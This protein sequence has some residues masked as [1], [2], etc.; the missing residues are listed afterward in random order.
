MRFRI[1][2]VLLVL[3]SIPSFAQ[4][5]QRLREDVIKIKNAPEDTSLAILLNDIGWDT[6]YENLEAGLIY[7]RR[8]LDLSKKLNFNYGIMVSANSLGTIYNDQGAYDSALTMH[9]LSLTTAQKENNLYSQ[10]TT[11]M[12]LSIVY[13]SMG[14]GAKALECLLKSKDI[15]TT[16][17]SNRG[18][19][20]VNNNLG[21]S[22][23]DFDSLG[24]AMVAFQL[25]DS[26]SDLLQ[27]PDYKAHA[28]SGLSD[29]YRRMEDSTNSLKY[30]R[31]T[32]AILD[33]LHDV[34]DVGQALYD[35][36]YNYYHFKEYDKAETTYMQALAIFRKVGMVDQ[37]KTLWGDLSDLYE[38]KGEPEKALVAMKRFHELKDSIVNEKVLSHQ[39][40]LEALYQNEKNQNKI[41][42]LTLDQKFQNTLVTAL[43][44]GV[45]L[46]IV[47]LFVIFNR[48]KLRKKTNVQLSAQNAIIEEKNKNI[49]DS[50]NYARR[51][52][53]AV[54]PS[55]ALLKEYFSDAVIFYRPRDIVSGDFWW[56]TG[57]DGKFFLAVADSTG[58]GV[59]GGF[60]SVMGAAFLSEIINE[61]KV[62]DA[63]EI[64]NVLR[65]K[66]VNALVHSGDD[67]K[68]VRD[69]MDMCMCV[70]DTKKME[71]E[72]A[73]ANNP[74]WLVRN[75]NLLETDAD[76][77][78]VGMHE[79]DVTPFTKNVITLQK[80]DVIWLFTDGFADQFGGKDG[81][82][83]KYKKMKE[84]F[85][86]LALKGSDE[87]ADRIQREF[88]AWKGELEQ[89]D[90]VLVVGIRI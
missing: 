54:L 31:R 28:L 66:V 81:K 56:F 30:I 89:V 34:Y 4:D 21:S 13:K 2:A 46:L 37:E 55:P 64:L 17:K 63:G 42:Q 69:G 12:N 79:G 65:D 3:F 74:L 68:S 27:R 18:I 7:C 58:H 29:C 86:D 32:I 8:A 26:L 61:K 51:I 49:T 9:Y 60:M 82:K 6:S 67:N 43:V 1:L 20:V 40:D 88:D 71:V 85:V 50:I 24:K 73:G 39:R 14:Q 25:S 87:Q 84:L 41:T 72:F 75:G 57:K 53:D 70:F 62:T 76:N 22:Y 59:P 78:P 15:Y 77:F 83:Y 48:S 35:L 16:L 38:A 52:Q 19:C 90:D 11:Y 33:S 36:A 45:L 5:K 47:L 44:S 10:G 80:N 23:L